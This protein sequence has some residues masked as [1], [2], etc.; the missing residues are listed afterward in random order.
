MA[1]LTDDAPQLLYDAFTASSHAD[2]FK[3]FGAEFDPAMDQPSGE[4]G[5]IPIGMVDPY[6]EVF[7]LT[8]TAVCEAIGKSWQSYAE[9]F[10]VPVLPMV[11]G[12][13]PPGPATSYTVAPLVI[14]TPGMLIPTAMFNTIKSNYVHPLPTNFETYAK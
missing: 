12:V 10:I 8:L 9:G 13:S 11:G 1:F 5:G 3:R 4:V 6:S 7:H 14:W 2:E